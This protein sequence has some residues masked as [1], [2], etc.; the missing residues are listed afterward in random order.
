MCY[1][2][3]SKL[4]MWF[5]HHYL[6]ISMVTCLHTALHT[7]TL[8][9][10]SA[11]PTCTP[12]TTATAP[13]SYTTLLPTLPPHGYFHYLYRTFCHTHRAVYHLKAHFACLRAHTAPCLRATRHHIFTTTL[14]PA[15][16]SAHTRCT[17]HTCCARRTPR[18][19]H[20]TPAPPLCLTAPLRAAAC[21]ST[22]AC[23]GDTR[24]MG[25]RGSPRAYC[26]TALPAYRA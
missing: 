25:R 9:C 21:I 19:V 18:A 3:Y 2:D 1:S 22:T 14:P 15:F 24:W 10:G 16:A 23:T 5:V 13:A 12:F 26:R 7:Y 20:T 11:W 8:R 6:P 17:T 4:R